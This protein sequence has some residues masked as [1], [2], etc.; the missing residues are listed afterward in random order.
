MARQR[1]GVWTGATVTGQASQA[2]TGREQQV[3]WQWQLGTG[4]STPPTK[5][6]ISTQVI[7]P[8]QPTV[9]TST[10]VRQQQNR[11]VQHHPRVSL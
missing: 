2:M 6:I 11:K 1:I 3:K 8:Y 5:G 10:Q 4:Q 7:H 9:F